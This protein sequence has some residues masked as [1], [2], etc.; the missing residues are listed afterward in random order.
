LLN[1]TLSNCSYTYDTNLD[2]TFKTAKRQYHRE[3][4][5]QYA[6][7]RLNEAAYE[8]RLGFT[9]ETGHQYLKDR[10]NAGDQDAQQ[11]LNWAA[12]VPVLGF[13]DETGHQ[14]L[15]DRA[16]AGD[17][18]AQGKLIQLLPKNLRVIRDLK[19]GVLIERSDFPGVYTLGEVMLMKLA[20]LLRKYR[21][22][23]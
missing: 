22:L 1:R 15:K 19:L 5:D 13:T 21:V 7:K 23:T 11:Q 3:Y 16:N 4:G 2:F 6:Q 10:A 17:Q 18:D 8:R 14:Y 12:Y 20:P 9:D